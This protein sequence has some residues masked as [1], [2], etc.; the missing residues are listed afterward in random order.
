MINR[1]VDEGCSKRY[2]RAFCEEASVG[3]DALYRR[4]DHPH[5]AFDRVVTTS[6]SRVATRRT[7]ASRYLYKYI[8]KGGRSL[9]SFHR[10]LNANRPA[11]APTERPLRQGRMDVACPKCHAQHRVDER[12]STSSRTNPKFNLYCSDGAVDLPPNRDP[13]PQAMMM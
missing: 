3:E 2:P 9:L 11:Q 13:P 1:P 5:T 6:V 12:I 7:S 4:R 10:S 8:F